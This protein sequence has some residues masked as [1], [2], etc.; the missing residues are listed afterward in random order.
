MDTP[1]RC[2]R[3]GLAKAD[4]KAA[5]PNEPTPFHWAGLNG[6]TEA[7]Q[8]PLAA[9]ADTEAPA[10]G[11]WTPPPRSAAG[12]AAGGT[13]AGAAAGASAGAAAACAAAGGHRGPLR[14]RPL[15]TS[16]RS[17]CRRFWLPRRK[18]ESAANNGFT[19]LHRTDLTGYTE[20]LEEDEW[21]P[22]LH[23]P[24]RMSTPMLR[25]RSRLLGRTSKRPTPLGPR[26]CTRP[27]R[28]G[29]RRRCRSLWLPRRTP[30]PEEY[31]WAPLRGRRRCNTNRH[32]RRSSRG[33]TGAAAVGAAAGPA[34]SAAAGGA[35]AGEAAGAA[36]GAAAASAAAGAT[37]MGQ[38]RCTVPL[39]TVRRTAAL[40]SGPLARTEGP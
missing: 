40:C 22:K 39:R 25:E 1:T 6:H 5:N 10:E 34:A 14:M 33:S 24:F 19:P 15:R 36:A 11:E 9:K 4:V 23:S 37:P 29:T 21:T 35:A 38:S 17:R 26:R 28:T 16:T 30:S 32:C 13:A 20:A 3:F 2:K 27:L 18:T 31:T 7:V 8:A 12:A